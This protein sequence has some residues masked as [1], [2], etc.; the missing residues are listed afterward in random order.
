MI[1]SVFVAVIVVDDVRTA[2]FDC[3]RHRHRQIQVDPNR[4]L[5]IRNVNGVVR[6]AL[7]GF[8]FTIYP[9]LMVAKTFDLQSNS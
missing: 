7:T 8:S 4:S 9:V 3:A 6:W 5:R 2:A 1:V